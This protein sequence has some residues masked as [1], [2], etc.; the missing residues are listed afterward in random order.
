MVLLLLLLVLDERICT[1]CDVSCRDAAAADGLCQ[2]RDW[3]RL[4]SGTPYTTSQM[5]RL[6][7]WRAVAAAV[8]TLAAVLRCCCCRCQ[9]TWRL[10]ADVW[11]C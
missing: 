7:L 2:Q 8:G 6:Q 5:L 11:A 9:A 1:Y 4:R 10:H 3:G